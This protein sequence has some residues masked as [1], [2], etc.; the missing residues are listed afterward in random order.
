MNPIYEFDDFAIET[1]EIKRVAGFPSSFAYICFAFFHVFYVKA[2]F[3]ITYLF[4]FVR[5]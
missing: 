5:C 3:M 1:F 2:A 4:E